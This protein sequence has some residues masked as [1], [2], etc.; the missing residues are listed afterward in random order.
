[1]KIYCLNCNENK[2][3]IFSNIFVEYKKTK[4]QF[5][6]FI[7]FFCFSNFIYKLVYFKKINFK[8]IFVLF[9]IFK[10]NHL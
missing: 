5:I 2:K 9:I 8:F 10:N 6:N 7:L 3:L 1:M 4:T